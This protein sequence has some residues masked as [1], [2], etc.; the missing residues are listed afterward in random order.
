MLFPL[1]ELLLSLGT[2]AVFEKAYEPP[3]PPSNNVMVKVITN[4]FLI[5]FRYIE[6]LRSF[7]VEEFLL[8][9]AFTAYEK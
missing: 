5:C 1:K 2:L 3:I 7:I 4:N 6:L 9:V 8:F